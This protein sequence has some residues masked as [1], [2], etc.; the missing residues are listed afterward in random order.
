MKFQSG[1]E[2]SWDVNIVRQVQ[3]PVIEDSWAPRGAPMP[4]SR[5]GR[6][7]RG[8]GGFDRGLVLDFEPGRDA[9]ASGAPSARLG[10][11]ASASAVRRERAMGDD[12]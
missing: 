3:H 11:H 9:K 2:Q 1:D 12:E 7:D 6:D 10:I 4:P 8:L 5:P